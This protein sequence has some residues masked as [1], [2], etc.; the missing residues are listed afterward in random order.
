MNEPLIRPKPY[1]L[2]DWYDAK[3]G[4]AFFGIHDLGGGY[5]CYGYLP[6]FVY[7]LKCRFWRRYNRVTARTLP[8]TW[9][10]ADTR[11]LHINFA[12]LESVIFGEE[13]FE[14]NAAD[15]DPTDGKSWAWALNEM[16]ELWHWWTVLRP[17]REAEY[18]RRLHEWS[19]LR[20][21]LGDTARAETTEAKAAW[22]KLQEMDEE[23]RDGEDIA[24]LQRLMKVSPYL[25][26]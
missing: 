3:R 20:G 8:P 18:D 2:R 16:R 9:C 4:L 26:T 19:V 1:G 6:E 7:Y 22:V 11:I 25:W 24:M 23:V 12:I 10:D 15:G 17:A 14:N 5:R 21:P 13:I